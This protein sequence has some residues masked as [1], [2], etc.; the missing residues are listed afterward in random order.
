MLCY[1]CLLFYTKG[2][3]MK[4]KLIPVMLSAGL[5]LFLGC[6]TVS[7]GSKPNKAV[8]E[9]EANAEETHV[10][11]Y[12]KGQKIVDGYREYHHGDL[13]VT[14]MDF[15]FSSLKSGVNRK[16]EIITKMGDKYMKVK[17]R[18]GNDVLVYMLMYANSFSDTPNKE[19]EFY[20]IYAQLKNNMKETERTGLGKMIYIQTP[21]LAGRYA[22]DFNYMA[23]KVYSF[24]FNRKGVLVDKE[25]SGDF[26]IGYIQT[27]GRGNNSGNV[28]RR[29]LSE[30]EI[31]NFTYV[32]SITSH[33]YVK[34]SDEMLYYYYYMP[35]FNPTAPK[36]AKYYGT[37]YCTAPHY[38]FDFKNIMNMGDERFF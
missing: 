38:C 26:I 16:E 3:I 33:S 25:L 15:F 1:N 21:E 32:K 31:S 35:V 18:K 10:I 11:E 30:D 9:Q 13:M 8:S 4:K 27:D 29:M 5:F 24:V 19:Q 6:S 37:Q 22:D 7:D 36:K 12:R 14:L 2:E 23:R 20:E 34:N 28:Y 17:D